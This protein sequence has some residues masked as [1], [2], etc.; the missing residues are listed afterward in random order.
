MRSLFLILF[1]FM[2][3]GSFSQVM[4]ADSLRS[5]VDNPA[6]G[7]KERPVLLRQLAEIYRINKNYTQAEARAREAII[8]ALRNKNYTDAVKAYTLITNVKANTRELAALKSISDSTLALAEKAN[9]PLAMAYAYYGIVWLYKTLDDADAVVK[10]CNLALKQLEKVKDPYVSAKMYYQ[11]Y[12]IYSKWNNDSLVNIYARKATES[13]LQTKDYNLLSNCYAALSIA[14][15]Y[16]YNAS[17]SKPEL[18]SVLFYLHQSEML[19]DK[20]PGQ[21][22]HYTEGI[23]CIN[24][25]DYYL[26]YFPAT[27]KEAKEQA[28]QYANTAR[29]I[30]NN[31]DG[32]REVQASSLGILSEYAKREGHDELAENYLLEA[33]ALMK[34]E[35]LP[36][37][38]TMINVVQ[39]LSDFYGEKGLYKKALDFQ[40]EVTLYNKK[41]F[42][43]QQALNAQK[44]EIQYETERKNEE[45][46]SLKEREHNRRL[47]NYLY[48]CIALASLFALLFVFKS[49]HFKLRYSQQRE[50]RLELEKLDTV[51]QMKLER[52]EQA[53]LK[54]EQQLLESQQQQLKTEAMANVL[55]LEH[56]NQMLLQIKD[57]LNVGDA[58]NIQKILREEM[59]LDSDFE[60]AKSQ[61][62]QVHPDFFNLIN[63]KAEKKLSLLDLKLCA[64]L[65]LKMDTTQISQLMNIEA[66]S[67]R[68]AKYRV[69]QKLGLDKGEDLNS[70]LQGIW[71]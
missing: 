35:E 59:A 55:Q 44:L 47:Q 69:K 1:M 49:Y 10:Y 70:F 14:H 29:M 11:L 26:K 61:I 15:E 27:D 7:E 17:K 62:Q 52:E 42:N 36:Y 23:A 53:R 9:D 67:V 46:R 18:D 24:I 28:V 65:Y 64:Y 2:P 16:N 32:S 45:M 63:E 68:M 33:Y 19:Y 5:V 71:S 43:E 37:Y 21:V 48:G 6:L 22:A 4:L 40:K 34:A 3:L 12:T 41:N 8:I 56:K 31:V 51:L 39:G 25:A 66:K 20:Y 54:V 38:H 13:A 58:V 57:K 30:M 50:K 60:Q